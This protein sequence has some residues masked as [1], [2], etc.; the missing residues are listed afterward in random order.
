MGV[1][2]LVHAGLVIQAFSHRTGIEKHEGLVFEGLRSPTG[3][4]KDPPPMWGTVLIL[5]PYPT[6]LVSNVQ[7]NFASVK[8]YTAANIG[9]QQGGGERKLIG[10]M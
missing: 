8:R 9:P 6:T 2:H 1:P 4:G 5:V 3:G 10:L 7:P